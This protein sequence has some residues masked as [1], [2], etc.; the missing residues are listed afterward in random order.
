MPPNLVIMPVVFLIIL[1]HLNEKDVSD[2]VA[3]SEVVMPDLISKIPFK[4][5]KIL[6]G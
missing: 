3:E 1:H 4:G 2:R 6:V 5:L